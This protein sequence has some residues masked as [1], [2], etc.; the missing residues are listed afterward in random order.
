MSIARTHHDEIFAIPFGPV[1][2]QVAAWWYWMDGVPGDSAHVGDLETTVI[3]IEVAGAKLTRKTCVSDTEAS[4]DRWEK[5][6][7]VWEENEAALQAKVLAEI[8]DY[9][10]ETTNHA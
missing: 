5:M 1:T 8:G 6:L 3:E 9:M 10:S 2:F 4:G 7:D